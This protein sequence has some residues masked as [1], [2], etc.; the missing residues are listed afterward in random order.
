MATLR[1]KQGGIY[2]VDCRYHGKRYR[3]STK[4]SDR[5]LADLFLKDIEVRIAKDKFG[6]NDLKQVSLVEFFEK[7][8]EFSRATKAENSYLLDRHSSRVFVERAG[9]LYLSLVDPK[10]IEDFKLARL[11]EVKPTSVNIELRHLRA[12]F[13]IAVTWRNLK[14]NPFSA[15]KQIKI[16][17]SN[18]PK[19]FSKEQVNVLLDS[20]PEGDF[21]NLIQFYLYTGLRRVEA[22]NLTWKDIDVDKKKITIREA[23]SGESRIIPINPV[24]LDILNSMEPNG[25]M[26]FNFTRW[27]VTHKFKDY[28]RASGLDDVENLTV[29][30]L[31]H[32]FAS[33]LVMEGTDLYTVAKLLGHSGVAVTQMYAHLAPDYLQ[34]SVERLEF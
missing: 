9:N 5:K 25:N 3:V 24:L 6:F 28:L 8:L 4:T 26:L 16:K 32:T 30:S 2:F 15:V 21:K 23:K 29:H 22:L 17:N 27:F 13:Q 33:H 10:L 12:M 31:R 11:R 7:Y 34:K 18:L 1:K 14:K 20:L 19:F